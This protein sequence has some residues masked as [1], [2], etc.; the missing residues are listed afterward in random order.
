[1]VGEHDRLR[2][3][4]TALKIKIDQLIYGKKATEVATTS[5]IEKK[6]AAILPPTFL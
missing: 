4:I 2:S 1:L 6:L 5:L 3:A